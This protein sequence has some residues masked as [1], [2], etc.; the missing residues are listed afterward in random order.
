MGSEQTT[1]DGMSPEARTIYREALVALGEGGA[2]FLIGG[3]YAF[4]CYTEVERHTKDLDLFVRRDDLRRTLGLLKGAGFTTEIP[5]PHWLAKAWRGEHFLDVIFTSG[6]GVALVD[7]GW[8][9]HAEQS[10]ILGVPVAICAPEE[11]IWSKAF[12]QERERYDGADVAHL[13][14]GRGATLDWRRLLDRFGDSWRVLFGHLVLFGFIY[15][16]ERALVP[17]WV[18]EELSSRLADETAAPPAPERICRGTLLSREQYLVDI[19][20]WGYADARLRPEGA[21]TEE[22]IARWTAAINA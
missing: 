21:M 3:A 11:L 10:E 1:F 19:D 13:I 2:P 6:N 20:Q 15:P 16:G 7:E 9:A 4:A 5:F 22:E 8:F 12:I 18:M 17:A 14:R